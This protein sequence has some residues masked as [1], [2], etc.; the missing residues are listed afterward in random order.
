MRGRGLGLASHSAT[1]LVRAGHRLAIASCSTQYSSAVQ[2]LNVLLRKTSGYLQFVRGRG[3]EPPRITPRAPK[4]R[5]STN[6][7]TPA[8]KLK[9]Q[10]QKFKITH[11]MSITCNFQLCTCNS[12]APSRDRTYDLILKRDLLYQLSYGRAFLT[13]SN[14]PDFCDFNNMCIV[15][16]IKLRCKYANACE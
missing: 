2:V 5:A 4:A 13:S 7:A 6:F 12:S 11:T 10:S 9:V 8:S 14:V 16:F 1:R 15:I 3:L